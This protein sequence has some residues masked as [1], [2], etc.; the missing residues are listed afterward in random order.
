MIKEYDGSL[1]DCEAILQIDKEVF[2]EIRV[3]A[4]ALQILLGR[5]AGYRVLIA[6]EAGEPAAYMGLLYASTLHYKGLWVDLLATRPK[7]QNHGYATTLTQKALEIAQKENLECVTAIVR[8]TNCPSMAV[9]NKLG[10]S[11]SA[12]D[13]TLLSKNL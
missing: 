11:H 5:L 4:P 8:P 9:F 6:Y 12:E 1:Q 13:Y 10:F 3:D 7:F 2:D